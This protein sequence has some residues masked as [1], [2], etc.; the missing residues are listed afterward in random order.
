[1]PKKILI[2]DDDEGILDALT[3]IL[4][5]YGYTIATAITDKEVYSRAKSF[6]PDLILL[7][8]LL[9]GSDG[10][11][12]CK[13]LKENPFTQKIPIIMVSAHPTAEKDT[14]ECKPDAF[15]AKPFET[16]QL[17]ALVA[18]LSNQTD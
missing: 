14:R 3:L 5:E 12:I 10:R 9:S 17:L 18:K 11:D 8:I 1:M 16:S 2:V 13:N 6:A 15:L 4:E 7:D